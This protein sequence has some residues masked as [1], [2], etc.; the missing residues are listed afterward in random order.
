MTQTVRA[1]YD[2]GALRLLEPLDLDQNQEVEVTVTTQAV[3]A[4]DVRF[5][6]LFGSMR[7][8][9]AREM[10]ANINEAFGQVRTD[11]W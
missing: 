5:D 9:E 8:E 4:E 10:L 6:D 3:P 2:N 11:E 7:H 1:I